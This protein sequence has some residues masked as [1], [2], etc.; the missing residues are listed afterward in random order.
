MAL[1]GNHKVEII[2]GVKD[3]ASRQLDRIGSQVA[4]FHKH[5]SN[6]GSFMGAF[7]RGIDTAIGKM[8]KLA[9]SMYRFNMYTS[10][11]R[12]NLSVFGEIGAIA[13]GGLAVQGTKK[14]MDFDYNTS[15]MQ[16]RMEGSPEMKKQIS[17]YI[18]NELNYKVAFSPNDIAKL[19]VT[20]GQGGVNNTPDM[21]DALKTSTYFAEAVDAD[22]NT[23]GEMIIAAAKGFR[24]SM[25]DTGTI[26]DKL[27]TALN[28]S[29]LRVEELPHAIGE[30]AGRA[31]LFGQSLDSSLTALMVGR[32]QGMSA[33][34]T[35]QDMLHGLRQASY[36]G[37][38]MTLFPRRRKYYEA[39]GVD[40]S[41]FDM[42]K[43]QMKEYPE[44]IA[45]LEKTMVNNGFTNQKY[46][47][48]SMEDMEAVK[49]DNGGVLPEDFWDNM[50]AAP[51]ISRVF[52]AA[53][54]APMMMG[55]QAKWEGVDPETG[56]KTG[57][58]KYGADAVKELYKEV[59][60]E[61][62][63]A[64]DKTHAIMEQT[65]TFQTEVLKGAFEAAQIKFLDN[66]VPV[67]KAGAEGLTSWL[68]GPKDDG[69]TKA[70]GDQMMG[71]PKTGL[72]KFQDAYRGAADNF[73]AE[74]NRGT[75]NFIEGT[76]DAIVG[77]IKIGDALKP[78][79]NQ[80][81]DAFGNLFTADWGDS[82]IELPLKFVENVGKF[83]LDV[84]KGSK[85]L[86]DAIEKLP[87]NLQ[88]PA[89]LA[90]QLAKG[91][92]A[93]L[94]AGAIVKVIEMA[95]RTASLTLKGAK[96]SK[97]LVEGILASLGFGGKGK[98]KGAA[99][100]L[101]GKGTMTVTAGV[102]NVYGKA[103]VGGV[104]GAAGAGRAG[105]PVILDRNGRPIPPSNSGSP[106]PPRQK[107]TVGGVIG[108]V[109]TY[110]TLGYGAY[111]AGEY[112]GGK[113]MDNMDKG[114][115]VRDKIPGVDPDGKID[116]YQQLITQTHRGTELKP[117]N[118]KADKVDYSKSSGITGGI[119]K[120]GQVNNA[121]SKAADRIVPPKAKTVMNEAG[122]HMI[123][124][125][126]ESATVLSKSVEKA[127][128]K[129]VKETTRALN[130]YS[131][132][133]ERLSGAAIKAGEDA[134]I[135]SQKSATTI[136]SKASNETV[137]KTSK[138]MT[139]ATSDAQTTAVKVAGKAEK[140][141][142]QQN[143]KLAKIFGVEAANM[144]TTISTKTQEISNVTAKGISDTKVQ[145]T[146]TVSEGVGNIN[147]SIVSGFNTANERLQNIKVQNHVNVQVG[148]PQVHISGSIKSVVQN[149]SSSG[150]YKSYNTMTNGE[151]FDADRRVRQLEKRIGIPSGLK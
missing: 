10:D 124:G 27:T 24:I 15:K 8:D 83:I 11:I 4:G 40:T 143:A 43:R 101:G 90:S 37:N 147:G 28:K 88:D 48:K 106:T 46:K 77:G 53:G 12:R 109:A 117:Y 54:M 23:A 42:D 5:F 133:S 113:M 32:D 119:P 58:V 25:D 39:L 107:P 136:S 82:L 34:Q 47:V 66:M 94:A 52:G 123:K 75:G 151:K 62:D 63:G 129:S 17:D 102:V 95:I 13:A 126:K 69:P 112:I 145:L 127:G 35:S 98:G 49:K 68:G 67:I 85:D 45:S 87:D 29:L 18:L 57:E 3:L 9:N 71:T 104:P 120:P 149:I 115:G 70:S 14:A 7:N 91:G 97:G 93:F 33:A 142:S 20:L 114:Q 56:E 139:K 134:L 141:N 51:L 130:T 118:P 61:S 132:K 108:G 92:L 128:S 125:V 2:V 131:K 16:S 86:S 138:A 80:I 21:K 50:K 103:G 135:K 140:N 76:G 111:K 55:L 36:I 78:L 121:V 72:E 38:E 150:S 122:G 99:S 84:G 110:A 60:F 26:S 74:G 105:G 96:V 64:T 89:Q 144:G 65:A 30:L 31:S 59:K 22:A 6:A 116:K 137:K 146:G 41:F 44:V 19:G 148:S 81:S 100:A 1:G 73:R 79:Y